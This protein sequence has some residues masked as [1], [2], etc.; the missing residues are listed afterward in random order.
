VWDSRPEAAET[1]SD[2]EVTRLSH[3]LADEWIDGQIAYHERRSAR[4]ERYHRFLTVLIV[5][6]AIGTIAFPSLHAADVATHAA[7]FFSILLPVVGLSL[8]AILTIRQ[9]HALASRY[10]RMQNDLLRV[11]DML[12]EANTTEKLRRSAFEAARIVAGEAGDW[13]G[14]M[15]FLDADH[16]G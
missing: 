5:L 6:L 7:V 3:V 8:G 13:L 15:W 11:R 2:D 16:P 10:R 9:H 1:L 14:A 12:L 4:H